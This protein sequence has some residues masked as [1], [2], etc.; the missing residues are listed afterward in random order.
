[1]VQTTANRRRGEETD[2]DAAQGGYECGRVTEITQH[3]HCCWFDAALLV[4]DI[5]HRSVSCGVLSLPALRPT[6][7]R[8]ALAVDG[9][10]HA[11]LSQV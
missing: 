1:M 11:A 6:G 7:A 4:W 3:M 2:E 9:G 10:G 8:D 5:D